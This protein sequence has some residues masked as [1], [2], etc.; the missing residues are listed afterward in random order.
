MDR[1]RQWI[2]TLLLALGPF[3]LLAYILTRIDAPGPAWF[4]V[5]V[6]A[7][8]D[9]VFGAL[10]FVPPVVSWAI[11]GFLLGGLTYLAVW[12]LREINR[13]YLRYGLLA[14]PWLI[15][16]TIPG[17]WSM[18]DIHVSRPAVIQ[19]ADETFQAGDVRSFQGIEFVWI[20]AGQ[21]RMGS[22]STEPDR[23]PDE[24]AHMATLSHG[25]WMGRYE[26]T[27]SQWYAVMKNPPETYDEDAEGRLPMTGVTWTECQ[28]FIA[29]L[30]RGRNGGFRL[31]TEAEWEYACRA[32][33]T[34]AYSCGGDSAC[35]AEHAWYSRNSE[36]RVH[37][38]GQKAPNP[39][40]LFDMHG[41]VWEWCRD[42]YGEYPERRAINPEGPPTG[43]HPVLR[44]GSWFSPPED[45]RAARRFVFVPG[46]FTDRTILGF[47]LAR[48]NN[49]ARVP[50]PR[51]P[52]PQREP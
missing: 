11:A 24:S 37:P 20:P 52:A 7:V 51:E 12:E 34:D 31:P 40:G 28:A 29:A 9:R 43:Q 48:T 22:P 17:A 44:G 14:A 4:A 49:P 5:A 16:L 2:V 15:V 35:L 3:C 47:R 25:F 33:G 39:W 45:C 50:A 18:L 26:V 32:G 27:R 30:N 46:Y 42:F 8:S 19:R 36:G 41:N 6:L 38:V 1:A 21:F 23:R 10:G 13:P